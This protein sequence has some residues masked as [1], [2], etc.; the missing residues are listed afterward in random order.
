MHISKD[1]IQVPVI[2]SQIYSKQNISE[3]AYWHL[4]GFGGVEFSEQ[5][6]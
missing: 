2:S 6:P 4:A 3:L 5:L 1:S